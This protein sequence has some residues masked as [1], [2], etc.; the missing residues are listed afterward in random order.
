MTREEEHGE[1]TENWMSSELY[2]A[3]ETEQSNMP[4]TNAKGY[5][6]VHNENYEKMNK[7]VPVA[8][9]NTIRMM[10]M[11]MF[12]VVMASWAASMIDVSRA[13]KKP[14]FETMD[15]TIET[16]CMPRNYD[17]DKE[18]TK[19]QVGERE[20]VEMT[21]EP[22]ENEPDDQVGESGGANVRDEE[23]DNEDNDGSV[24]EKSENN[25]NK[26]IETKHSN[27]T[28]LKP[29]QMIEENKTTCIED[30]MIG[31]ME[32][33]H[34]RSVR[35]C[36]ENDLDKTGLGGSFTNENELYVVKYKETM[37]SKNYDNWKKVIGDEYEEMKPILTNVR[38]DVEILAIT[39]IMKK[40]GN[41]TYRARK[42]PMSRE[43]HLSKYTNRNVDSADSQG[44]SVGG[45]GGQTITGLNE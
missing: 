36:S 16:I 41:G 30:C 6:E 38:N 21:E 32:Q 9:V 22:S 18:N 5:E 26:L 3:N 23:R 19:V 28:V 25:E 1:E 13:L 4:E 14:L 35:K 15:G 7:A 8:N 31:S 24:R 33:Q 20:Q 34:Y 11:V 27:G 39:W 42:L 12:I 17:D 40:N 10:I 43:K 45:V 2:A 29:I 44:E 37:V